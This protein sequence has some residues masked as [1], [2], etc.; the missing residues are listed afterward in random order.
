MMGDLFSFLQVIQ[1]LRKSC[2]EMNEEELAK[3]SVQ[4]LNCQSEAEGREV[5]P[6]T[7]DMVC[8]YVDNGSSLSLSL[9]LFR[10]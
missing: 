2:S 9:S 4:L 1:A 3:M 5:F 6:C 10:L 7:S 8:E